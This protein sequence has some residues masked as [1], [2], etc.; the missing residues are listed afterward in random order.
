MG[1]GRILARFDNMCSGLPQSMVRFDQ[2][3]VVFLRCLESLLVLLN[4]RAI[5]APPMQNHALVLRSK[6][7]HRRG[8][9]CCSRGIE[10][11]PA[12]GPPMRSPCAARGPAIEL[13]R[14]HRIWPSSNEFGPSLAKP[15]ALNGKFG[16]IWH[17]LARLWPE[18]PHLGD[19][20]LDF[21]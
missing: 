16:R 18:L 19:L 13:P 9:I 10:S 5:L 3:R 2:I 12:Q 15:C 8:G 11:D 7:P 21:G 1:F 17:M 20:L 4:C 14:L 6:N